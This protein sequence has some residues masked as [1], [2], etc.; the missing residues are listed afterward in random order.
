M[1]I[2]WF[3]LIAFQAWNMCFVLLNPSFLQYYTYC[4][5]FLWTYGRSPLHKVSIFCNTIAFH[6]FC[7]HTL[8][9]KKWLIW[10]MLSEK[11]ENCWPL[12]WLCRTTCVNLHCRVVDCVCSARVSLCSD[13][14]AF[15]LFLSA[16]VFQEVLI[17]FLG[18]RE[19]FFWGA[20][21]YFSCCETFQW[22]HVSSSE[23]WWNIQCNM[24]TGKCWMVFCACY[25]WWLWHGGGTYSLLLL[26][27]QNFCV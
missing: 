14:S 8:F 3:F 26:L 22:E 11:A 9:S 16:G 21:I 24:D 12:S 20:P 4:N 19:L 5:Q 13:S 18:L 7:Q 2:L 10:P 25:Y 1:D 17:L 23:L 27:V 6:F 15:T